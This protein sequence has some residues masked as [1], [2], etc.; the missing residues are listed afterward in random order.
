MVVYKIVTVKGYRIDIISQFLFLIVETVCVTPMRQM[1]IPPPMSAYQLQLPS[2]VNMVVSPA[3]PAN[4]TN[5]I[6]ILTHD[7]Q[8]FVYMPDVKSMLQSFY[9]LYN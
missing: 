4:A 7:N 3:L 5:A 1:V 2:P 6:A 9:I 8:L